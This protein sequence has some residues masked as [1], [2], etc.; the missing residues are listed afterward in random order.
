MP[1][2]T[3]IWPE[4]ENSTLAVVHTGM[5][6]CAPGHAF[7]PGVRDYFL[8][9]FVLAGHG[10]F[11]A[12]ERTHHLGPG[13]GFLIFPDQV[14][15]YQADLADPWHYV[16]IG[17]QGMRAAECVRL[18]GLTRQAPLVTDPSFCPPDGLPAD[19]SACP[20][21]TLTGCFRQIVGLAGM[22][23]GRSLRQLAILHLFL[24]LLIEQNPDLPPDENQYERRAWYVRQARD[25]LEMN[26]ARKIQI[27]DLSRQIGLDRSYFGAIFRRETGQSPQQYL[28]RL[29]IAKACRLMAFSSLPIAG[30]AHSVGYEDPLLFSRMFRQVMGCSPTRYRQSLAGN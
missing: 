8:F 21:Q 18:A 3:P 10:F 2:R 14:T 4:S 15:Y 23:R 12:E 20:D 5:E 13:Q 27:A 6:Q 11:Q 25:Y 7:G 17:F 16:W 9:H 24:S 29:R 28:L 30:I 22:S 19:V 1:Y 26:Y